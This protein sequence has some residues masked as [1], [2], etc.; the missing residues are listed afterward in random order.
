MKKEYDYY[1]SR[2]RWYNRPAYYAS[3]AGLKTALIEGGALWWELLKT[4]EISNS[5][6]KIATWLSAC[7][8][9]FE[10]STSFGAVSTYGISCNRNY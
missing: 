7:L 8:D 10:H 5:Q 2:S 1:R 9:M 3:R 6:H 4:N